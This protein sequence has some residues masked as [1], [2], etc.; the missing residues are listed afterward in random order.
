MKKDKVKKVTRLFLK[1]FKS[2]C[3]EKPVDINLAVEEE[4][5]DA[6]SKTS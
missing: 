5:S 1:L 4:K 3:L 2:N 6:D